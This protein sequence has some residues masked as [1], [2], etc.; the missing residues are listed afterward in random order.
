MIRWGI[1]RRGIYFVSTL[2]VAVVLALVLTAALMMVRG[3]LGA[4]VNVSS[5][6]MALKAAESGL[7]YAQARLGENYAWRGDGAGVI[8]DTPD[9]MVREENGNVVGLLRASGG[10]YAQF[11]IRFNYQDDALWN[12][13]GLEDPTAE[14][15]VSHPYVSVNNI[16]GGSAMPVPRATGPNYMV[17]TTSPRPYE[18][19]SGTVAV[20]VEGRA[21]YGLR[22]VSP[23]DLNAALGVNQNV[24]VRV[25][26]AYLRANNIPGLDAA[27]MAAGHI[28]VNLPPGSKDSMTVTDK[29]KASIPRVRSKDVVEVEAGS[30]VDGKYVSDSGEVYATDKALHASYDP[31]KVT[32]M[33][34]NS[35]DAF[36]KLTWD[37]VKKADPASGDQTIPAGTYVLWDDGTLHYYDMGYDAYVDYIEDNPTDA[38]ATPI[39]PSN[40]VFDKTKLTVKGN[41]YAQETAAGTKEFNLIPREGAQEDI[42]GVGGEEEEEEE[43][44]EELAETVVDT[45]MP[46]I[47][48][49]YSSSP[50]YSVTWTVPLAGTVPGGVQEYIDPTGWR[51][52][53]KLTDNGDGTG[54]LILDDKN[55]L[56][57]NP[58]LDIDPVGALGRALEI[59]DEEP[60]VQA[61]LASIAV[62]TGSSGMKPI[63]LGGIDDKLDPDKIEVKFEPPAGSSAILSAEG[64]VRLG[65]RVTGV[66]GSITSAEDIS[67]IG[68]GSDLSASL[69]EGLNLYAQGDIVLSSLKQMKAD[70]YEYKNFKMKGVIYSWGDFK[71]KIGYDDAKVK[72]WG[73]FHL[74]GALVA[75]GGDPTGAPGAGGNGAVDIAAQKVDLIFD[76]AYLVQI[77]RT[78]QPGPLSQT[79]Y[80]VY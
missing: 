25:V 28:R 57:L 1:S 29:S 59:A 47:S 78:P 79:F 30:G 69:E 23:T 24:S 54:T 74:E 26:E 43:D 51:G 32:P 10:D 45:V 8:V 31:T 39:L 62:G 42:P 40:L 20:L 65:A 3:N 63:D 16:Q 49:V 35:G 33:K 58:R 48:S 46:G 14:M 71:A 13:D 6:D 38:G 9:L 66:G 50:T 75:Y 37:D 61:I 12:E 17:E 44:Y 21:G 41:I 11:R 7:R 55:V 56:N 22:D 27:A 60:A 76:P 19:P 77:E 2:L 73:S 4:S 72:K 18:V 15:W 52:F 36:Y 80:T 64:S 34:E 67:I 70:E 68:A 5:A 53:I